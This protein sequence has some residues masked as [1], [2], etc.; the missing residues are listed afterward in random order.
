MQPI[1]RH[2]LAERTCLASTLVVA[3]NRALHRIPAIE[4]NRV[5]HGRRGQALSSATLAG[6]GAVH[7]DTIAGI[8]RNIK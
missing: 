7:I 2:E 5:A 8:A 3:G 1:L 4:A 6:G